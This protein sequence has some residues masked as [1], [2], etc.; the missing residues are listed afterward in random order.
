[1]ILDKE[2]EL[3][4]QQII[5]AL[6]HNTRQSICSEANLA[7][8]SDLPLLTIRDVEKGNKKLS[9][10]EY[11]RIFKVLGVSFDYS[12][13]SIQ[14]GTERLE[15]FIDEYIMIHGASAG[16]FE[17]LNESFMNNQ[18]YKYTYSY[19]VYLI[20][21]LYDPKDI[22][23][24][25]E[26]MESVI[27]YLPLRYK[28]FA[29]IMEIHAYRSKEMY[30]NALDMV[31]KTFSEVTI[32]SD[33]DL[34]GVIYS[35]QADV[36]RRINRTKEAEIAIKQA[37]FYFEKGKNNRRI[38][39]TK[40][41]LGELY[42]QKHYYEEALEE[43]DNASL[44][45]KEN[46]DLYNLAIIYENISGCFLQ[47]KMYEKCLEYIDKSR[48]LDEFYSPI[49]DIN[50]LITYFYQGDRTGYIKCCESL[51]KIKD[52]DNYFYTLGKLLNLIINKNSYK[53]I[54]R[55]LDSLNGDYFYNHPYSTQIGLI[56]LI[57]SY[58]E[59]NG[60]I[61]DAYFWQRKLLQYYEPDNSLS[62][63]E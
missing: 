51:M 35:L 52:D 19:P 32:N 44:I 45:A 41:R 15:H 11:V 27:N 34:L 33:P 18:Y 25:I 40:I 31:E 26:E 4:K 37:L 60:K 42:Q 29:R 10:E 56:K 59:T 28:I 13:Q 62:I 50:A 58:F 9:I 49:Y 39:I 61:E 47:V 46:D 8:E 30:E 1:M 3:Y 53:E 48:N 57:L 14:S 38:L 22:S 63:L 20:V 36:L 7:V 43:Y 24:N 23:K 21:Q 55:L 54:Q 2:K 6:I 17:A 12:E 16:E 5:G